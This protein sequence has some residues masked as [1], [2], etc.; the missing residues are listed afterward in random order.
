[1][2]HRYEQFIREKQYLC[3]VSPSTVEGHLWACKAFEPALT[4]RS[5]VT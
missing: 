2:E 4:G 3:N 1:M 5:S